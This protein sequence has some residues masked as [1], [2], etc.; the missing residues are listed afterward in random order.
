MPL[1]R[2]HA[3][4]QRLKW[5]LKSLDADGVFDPETGLLACESFW[6][7]LGKAVAGAADGSQ[8]LLIA[9]YSFDG[10]TDARESR[11]RLACDAADPQYRLCLP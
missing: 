7:D 2:M 3:F 11:R 9:R 4:Q 1:V 8:A 10:P 6:R 5:M